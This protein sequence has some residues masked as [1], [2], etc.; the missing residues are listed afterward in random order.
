MAVTDGLIEE[1]HRWIPFYVLAVTMVIATG[2]FKI[3]KSKVEPLRPMD[4]QSQ[5]APQADSKKAS[6]KPPMEGLMA[7]DFTLPTLDGK[8]MKLSDHRGKI[9]FLNIWATW[10]APCK[11]EMPSMEKL[12]ELMRGKDFVM[13]TVSIDEK[14]ETVEAFM[15][16]NK[17][18]MPVGLDSLQTVAPQYRI[19]GVPESYIIDKNGMVM[20]HLI[21]PGDW[22]N[23]G[24][25]NA[26]TSMADKPYVKTAAK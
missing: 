11:E 24:I 22:S 14:K 9:V 15:K 16:E 7:P 19:T 23:P 25:V 18:T 20:H 5:Q 21:G 10:C 1:K 3:E 17:L 13:L 4:A 12:Y 2:F 8:E 26:L 6:A